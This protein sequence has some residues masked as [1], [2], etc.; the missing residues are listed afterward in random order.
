MDKTIVIPRHVYKG[1]A[2]VQDS[3][4]VDMHDYQ[5]V[6]AAA[7][8]AGYDDMAEWLHNNVKIYKQG[9]LYGMEPENE[10]YEG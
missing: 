10:D 8:Q 4:T 1:I 3:G 2:A 7:Q 9:M 5:Q 6:M